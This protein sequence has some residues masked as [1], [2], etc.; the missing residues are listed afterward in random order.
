MTSSTD[1]RHNAST[2]EY[3]AVPNPAADADTKTTGA[4]SGN[5]D[6]PDER[7]AQLR[8]WLQTIPQA[9]TLDLETL[10]PASSD[11]GFRRYFRLQRRDDRSTLIAMDAP[12]PEKSREFIQIQALLRDAGVH[13][14]TIYA[15]DAEQGFMLLEDMGTTAYIDVLSSEN[16]EAARPLMRSALESLLLWQRASQPAVLPPYDDALLRRE[17]NLFPEWYL[18]RHLNVTL[19]ATEAKGLERVFQ[20][21][22]D[23]ALNQTQCFVLRDFMPRNLM[24]PLASPS[25]ST[26][27]DVSAPTG[28]PVVLDFQDAVMGPATYDVVSLLRDAFISWDESFDIDCIAWYW[29]KAKA[30]GLPVEPDFAEYYRQLEWTGL[31]RHLKILGLFARLNYRDGK[32]RYLEDTPRFMAYARRTAG[33]YKD[34]RPLSRLLDKLDNRTETIGYTF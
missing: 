11:A 27:A 9:A 19:D 32:P 22:I 3:A 33:R 24:M 5:V 1:P 20:L 16:P 13:V 29:G 4:A 7:L 10:V 8:T 2:H 28:R 26:S 18:G 31:Q 17:L 14:P 15:A 25:D 12:P 30:A 34:L 23:N 21:L 6:G